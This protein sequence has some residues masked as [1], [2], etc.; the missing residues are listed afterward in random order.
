MALKQSSEFT[1]LKPTLE[2][3]SIDVTFDNFI[4]ILI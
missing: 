4:S 1:A 3:K 2:K